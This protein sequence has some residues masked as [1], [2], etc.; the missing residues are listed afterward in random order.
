MRL[1][2]KTALIAGAGRDSGRVIALTLRR[3]G[4]DVI[5]SA[6][7]SGDTIHELASECEAL[8]VKALTLLGDLSNEDEVNRMTR[9]A[10][11][12]MGKVDIL[13]SVAAIR[14]AKPAWEYTREEWLQTF[15]V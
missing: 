15:D 13:V 5:L 14:P 2:G 12:K 11:E 1:K 9:V 6:R 7:K 10:M 8:G 3:E 4:A